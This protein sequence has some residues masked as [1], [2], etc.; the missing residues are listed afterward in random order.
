VYQPGIHTGTSTV[1][2]LRTDSRL[3]RTG[4]GVT[5]NVRYACFFMVK[6]LEAFLV[7]SMRLERELVPDFYAAHEEQHRKNFWNAAAKNKF[8]SVNT[9]ALIDPDWLDFFAQ[10][11]KYSTVAGHRSIRNNDFRPIT[12]PTATAWL[13]LAS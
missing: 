7:E 4:T 8:C 6:T 2:S 3:L 13:A 12:A 5:S 1:E 10:L 9:T 11:K